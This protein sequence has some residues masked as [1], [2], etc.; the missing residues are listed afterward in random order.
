MLP[1]PGTG[2]ECGGVGLASGSVVKL[3]KDTEDGW[4]LDAYLAYIEKHREQFPPN[5]LAFAAASWHYNLYDHKCPHDS[6]VDSISINELASGER[7]EVRSLEIVVKLLGAFHDGHIELRYVD[8]R[9][10]SL[11]HPRVDQQRE[12]AHDDWLVDE[13][14]IQADGSV[15]HE[16]EFASGAAWRIT[17][18]DI[19]YQWLPLEKQ[20]D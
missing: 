7:S 14:L 4:V 19:I 1:Q 5:A 8:V 18:A 12:V 2:G 9:R 3:I 11:N 15:S 10:Y 17:C 6:W 13:I 16:I 20:P